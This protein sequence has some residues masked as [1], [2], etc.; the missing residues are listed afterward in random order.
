LRL[1][2]LTNF[3]LAGNSQLKSKGD[4]QVD[5]CIS[6]TENTYAKRKIALYLRSACETQ[7]ARNGSTA[8]QLSK[9]C[10]LVRARNRHENYGKIVRIFED[11][12]QSGLAPDRPG[13][14][15]LITAVECGDV[16]LV[17]VTDIQRISRSIQ[18]LKPILQTI[19]RSGA[20]L[21]TLAGP[22]PLNTL[23]ALY[24]LRAA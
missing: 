21:E 17:L 6:L 18:H 13:L 8:L 19:K 15:A 22:L 1:S 10:R 23:I 4:P 14:K 20:E 7:R 9:L 12:G 24:T 3:P 16:N 11:K 5:K 2:N